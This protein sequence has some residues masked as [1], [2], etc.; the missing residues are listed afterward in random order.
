MIGFAN[1]APSCLTLLLRCG[2][3]RAS[4]LVAGD[5][6]GPVVGVRAGCWDQVSGSVVLCRDRPWN[7][8]LRERIVSKAT[9]QDRA[10]PAR[11]KKPRADGGAVLILSKHPAPKDKS[12][13][14]TNLPDPRGSI[15]SGP[16]L[17][18]DPLGTSIHSQEKS[19][20]SHCM[21]LSGCPGVP[22][23]R[24]PRNRSGVQITCSH[25]NRT[26]PMRL[27]VMSMRPLLMFAKPA[28]TRRGV[29]AW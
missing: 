17:A 29:S 26:S 1:A 19:T 25:P 7:A 13:H 4:D 9:L 2:A 5:R 21:G 23:W 16:A 10:C 28:A 14:K 20:W 8:S 11:T 15:A 22:G 3:D 12:G 6:R 27:S 24:G 18:A